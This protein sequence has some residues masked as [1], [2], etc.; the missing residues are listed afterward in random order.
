MENKCDCN[1]AV[2]LP[3]G[4]SNLSEIG[5][6]TGIYVKV[7]DQPG[8]VIEAFH[9]RKYK[10]NKCSCIITILSAVVEKPNDQS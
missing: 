5:N 3:C 1:I 4:H 7:Q 2:E 9:W 10:C 8:N 6:F